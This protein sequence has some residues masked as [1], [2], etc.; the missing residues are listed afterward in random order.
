M[1]PRSSLK[2]RLYYILLALAAA[3]RH[4]LSIARDVNALSDG[5]VR[6]WPATLYGSLDELHDSAGLTKSTIR[7]SARPRKAKSAA[8]SGSQP[9]AAGC[10][11]ARPAV[12]ATSS[13][14]QRRASSRAR[15]PRHDPPATPARRPSL[16]RPD[17]RAAGGPRPT[18][19]RRDEVDVPRVARP[20]VGRR[21]GGQAHRVWAAATLRHRANRRGARS[22]CRTARQPRVGRSSSQ[23]AGM[24]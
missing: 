13:T 16:S 22:A 19:R 11:P 21:A 17:R 7:A 8:S 20:G 14:S 18:A 5:Q 1:P 24:P 23:Q 2:P 4:G 3:D 15:G 6:L 10:S 9:R 12:W